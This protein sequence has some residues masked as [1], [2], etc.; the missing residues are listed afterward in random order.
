MDDDDIGIEKL[1]VDPA[2]MQRIV[3][4]QERKSKRKG[5]QRVY[6]MLPREWEL[7]LLR[8]ETHQHLPPGDRTALP[9]LVRQRKACHRVQQGGAGGEN[10]CPLEMGSPRRTGT[11]GPD[12]GVPQAAQVASRR[13]A[14][15]PAETIMS[16]IAHSHIRAIAPEII[17][18]MRAIAPKGSPF[19]FLVLLLSS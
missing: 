19:S 9:A 4:Q 6:T 12:R 17:R 18:N 15:H 10:L 11:S 14:P 16:V 13:A 8:S 7:R 5:W 1:R 3:E 2:Q